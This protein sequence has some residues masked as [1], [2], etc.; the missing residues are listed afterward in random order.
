MTKTIV[1]GIVTYNPSLERLKNNIAALIDQVEQIYIIDNSSDNICQ[2]VSLF[3]NDKI[4]IIA[5]KHNTGL[6]HAL[7]RLF[8][9]TRFSKWVLTLDQDSILPTNYIEKCKRY[10]DIQNVGII[11]SR[12]YDTNLKSSIKNSYSKK[13]DIMHNYNYIR[14]TITSGALVNMEAY[15]ESGGYDDDLFVD[16]VDFDFSV[17]LTNAGYKILRMNDVEI[18]HELG[19]SVRKTFLFWKVRFTEHSAKREYIIARNIIIFAR[20]Y[21]GVEKIARDIMSI[22]KHIIQ[23][24]LYGEQKRYKIKMIFKGVFDGL[25]ITDISKKNYI[26]GENET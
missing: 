6:G 7:N 2:I 3:E 14:R 25:K 26:V 15:Q 20:R 17:R 10:I 18:E 22:P 9:E 24:A 1:A 16:Y 8:Y 19:R 21:H 11:T 23:I 5:L 13:D 4:K 12:K